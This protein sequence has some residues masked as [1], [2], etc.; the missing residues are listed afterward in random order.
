MVAEQQE[1]LAKQIENTQKAIAAEEDKKDTD[2]E[3]IEEL[4][5]EIEE[6]SKQIQELYDNL[7]ADI[8]GTFE[9]L[10]STLGDAMI[11]ALQQGEDALKAWSDSVNDIITDI[12]G[13]LLIQKYLEP[14][15]ANLVNDYYSKIM[16]KNARAENKY[17]EYLKA[18]ERGDSAAAEKLIEE[19]KK[20]AEQAIGEVPKINE[21]ATKQFQ[22][23]LLAA[24]ENFKDLIPDWLINS[25]KEGSGLSSLQKGIQG[26]TEST[27][28]VLEAIANSSRGYLANIDSKM[29]LVLANLGA[30]AEENP[31]L[32]QMRLVAKNTSAINTLLNSLVKGG[33]PQGGQGLKVF[34]D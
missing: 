20:L 10:S 32:E 23:D 2:K 3:R 13:Q 6:A 5:G 19:Y 4:Q 18:I 14:Q 21:D 31:M 7:R 34:M 30:G 33:H 22:S 16:P 17:Q 12:V 25:T 15:I 9:D 27:A 26:I 28:Q 1:N 8:V 24:G 11:S 29:D